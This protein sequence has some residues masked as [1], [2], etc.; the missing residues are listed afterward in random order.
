MDELLS[1][2]GMDRLDKIERLEA[3]LTSA[4][5]ANNNDL[6]GC[7]SGKGSCHCSC[8]NLSISSTSSQT[9][10]TGDIVITN[11]FCNDEL[12]DKEKVLIVS[13]KKSPLQ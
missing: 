2:T 11:V 4:V 5:S 6:G 12:K 13:P 7:N 3:L 8:H 1:D 10:S 9:L